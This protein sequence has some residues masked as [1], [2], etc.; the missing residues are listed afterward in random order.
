M[1]QAR[2]LK[3]NK[4]IEEEV[5]IDINGVE[6]V[7][8]VNV[9]P[10][11]IIPNNVYSVDIHLTFLDGPEL[12]EK[13]GKRYGLERVG[14]SYKYILYGKVSGSCIDIGKGIK[15]EDDIFKQNSYLNGHFIEIRPDRLAIEFI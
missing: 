14:S 13:E 7:G 8:F 12:I 11:K 6:I 2:L 4:L 1:Y 5:T 10:Y 9:C 15:I 3:L